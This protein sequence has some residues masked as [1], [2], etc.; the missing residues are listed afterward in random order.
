M[1]ISGIANFFEQH[2][3]QIAPRIVSYIILSGMSAMATSVQRMHVEIIF[4]LTS[5]TPG[6][7]TIYIERSG[8]PTAR[9]LMLKTR[10]AMFT[11]D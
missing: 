3:M 10:H 7:I 2:G 6:G 9:Q 1:E 5:N 4:L 8:L 11:D